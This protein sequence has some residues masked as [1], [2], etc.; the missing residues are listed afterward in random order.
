MTKI[1]KQTSEKRSYKKL[2]IVLGVAA[3]FFV[4]GVVGALLLPI[5]NKPSGLPASKD[6]IGL[7]RSSVDIAYNEADKLASNGK[8]DEAVGILDTAIAASKN[9]IEKSQLVSSKA[10]LF[11]NQKDFEAA[12]PIALEAHRIHPTSG[13][14]A[15]IGQVY[16]TLDN[17]PQAAAYYQKAAELLDPNHEVYESDKQ[18]YELKARELRQ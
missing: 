9:P 7:E 12:L 4:S 11:I 13:N 17:R 1:I 3:L 10:T 18:Y 2:C 6:D 15:L 5:L 14:A 8:T 16:Q